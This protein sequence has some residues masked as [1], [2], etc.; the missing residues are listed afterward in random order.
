VNP[1]DPSDTLENYSFKFKSK[2]FWKF[3]GPGL[4][5][6]MAFLDP[7]NIA[8]DLDA[9]RVGGNG[10]LWVLFWSTILGCWI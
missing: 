5:M 9:G 7:G 8:G 1:D 2:T 3:F 10:L 4:L 6:A